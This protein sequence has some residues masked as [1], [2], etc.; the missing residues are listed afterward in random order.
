MLV[1]LVAVFESGSIVCATAPTSNAL[2]IGR[3]IAAIGG[4]GIAPGAFVLISI[5]VPLRSRP[6]YIGGLGSM[7]GLASIIGP[8]TSGYLTAVT[9][10]W[11]FWINVPIG[12]MSFVLLLALT[13]KSPPPVKPANTW[14]EKIAQLDPL[15]FIL[16]GPSVICLLFALQW[17]GTKFTWNNGRIIG[18]FVIFGIFGF[19]FIASQAWRKDQATVPPQVF[20]QRSI[21]AGSIANFGIGSVLVVYAFYLP[22]WFQVIQGKSPQNSGLSLIPLL[23]SIVIAVIGGGI[24]TSTVLGYYTPLMIVGS[25]I[26]IVGSALITTWEANTGNGMWIGYQV[27]WPP[28]IYISN[29]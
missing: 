17:G 24:A 27:R 22:I 21:L 4:A 10:R 1:A 5:F 8:V 14:H 29:G 7:F 25:A 18:L 16:I 19:A 12:A 26:L 2:I 13:P 20:L 9:W 11:C 28:R 15:G 23:L 3:A 6:K